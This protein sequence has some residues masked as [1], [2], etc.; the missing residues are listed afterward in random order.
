[1]VYLLTLPFRILFGLLLLPFALL[2]L[3]FAV[4]LL[5]FLIL[6]FVVKA[7]VALVVLP[8]VLLIGAIVC[9]ALAIAFSLAILAPLLPFAI[10]ALL[11]WA[12][13]RNSPA[14]IAARG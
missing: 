2:A 14:A 10:I 12:I 13:T 11:V 8:F 5:P 1:M 6:R 4:L 3:P 9:V 7:A